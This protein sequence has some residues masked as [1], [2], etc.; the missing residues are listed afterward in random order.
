VLTAVGPARWRASERLGDEAGAALW[1]GESRGRS[2]LAF[3][4][5]P[6]LLGDDASSRAAALVA[7]G[8]GTD[9]H[10]ALPGSWHPP[11]GGQPARLVLSRPGERA[12]AAMRP[13]AEAGQL[14]ELLCRLLLAEALDGL[15]A[16]HRRGFAHGLLTPASLWLAGASPERL[17]ADCPRD[18]RVAIVGCGVLSLLCSSARAAAVAAA[19]KRGVAVAPE[20]RRGADVGDAGAAADL[21]ALGTIVRALSPAPAPEL[22][23]LLST[24]GALR[25]DGRPSAEEAGRAARELALAGL[26]DWQRTAPVIPR[27]APEVAPIAVRRARPT[28]VAPDRAMSSSRRSATSSQVWRPPL[29]APAGYLS[30]FA[31]FG[32]RLTAGV[33][34][35]PAL[36]LSMAP[37]AVAGV[38]SVLLAL[39]LVFAAH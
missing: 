10:L 39:A 31:P 21:W 7:A 32:A 30:P 19:V 27:L 16:A 33:Q 37:T 6:E 11:A 9:R 18:P 15:A 26:A 38:L 1:A 36:L 2:W 8:E 13:H 29:P 3:E 23:R 20:L 5:A 34:A 12:V 24:L 14:P 4:I 17:V 22:D 28:P 35:P 25:P